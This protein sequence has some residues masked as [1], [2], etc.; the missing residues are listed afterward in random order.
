M[1]RQSSN[2]GLSTLMLSTI[3][4]AAVLYVL[5]GILIPLVLAGFLAIIF[6]PV[7]HLV[8]R[9]GLPSW[10]GILLVLIVAAGAHRVQPVLVAREDSVATGSLD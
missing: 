10:V 6:K 9:R 7:V 3:A 4:V 8:R 5:H 1:S 2:I